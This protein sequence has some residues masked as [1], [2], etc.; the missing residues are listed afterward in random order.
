MPSLPAP[1]V[2][3]LRVVLVLLLL[4][5][6]VLTLTRLLQP[7]V[8]PALQLVAFTPFGL[9]GHGAAL[10][11]AVL[12]LVTAP[13]VRRA[14]APLA[15][16]AVVGLALHAV[17]FAPQVLGGAPAP[18]PDGE[19]RVVMGANLLQGGAD[20]AT[21]VRLVRE[22]KVQVL[23]ASEITVETLRGLEEAGIDELL[24]HRAG[25]P[26]ERGSV[27]G[28][29][30]FSTGPVELVAQVPTFSQTLL[31]RT[32]GVEVLAVH[33]SPPTLPERWREDAAA[34]LDAVRT[35]EPDVVVGDFNATD[36]H[37]PILE[38][39]DDGWRSAARLQNAGWSPTWPEGGTYG[40]LGA[41]GPLARIDHV[42][43]GPGWTT[44]AYDD[45]VVPGTDHRAV[46]ATVATV[47]AR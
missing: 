15:V 26:G 47:A 20:A 29:M 2:T 8:G 10:L 41:L 7:G 38:L 42:L 13:A 21:V 3:A 39:H 30:V 31:V 18:G 22:E 5:S 46:V 34:V 24:P 25:E 9:L 1:V 40:L 28:T 43:V 19:R 12:L 6:T 33:P 23:A 4:G 16:V 17:W 35:H 14:T 11:L 45:H 44:T 36:D 27:L 37:R 32:G